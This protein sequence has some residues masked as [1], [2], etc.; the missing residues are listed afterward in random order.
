M[1]KE[2]E[3]LRKGKESEENCP[4]HKDISV[5]IIDHCNANDQENRMDF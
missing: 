1:V 2:S 4:N 5:Q 3:D